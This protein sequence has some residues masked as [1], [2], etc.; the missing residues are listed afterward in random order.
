MS[1]D[2]LQEPTILY[3]DDQPSHLALF[4]RAFERD[5]LV[6]TARNG[7]EGIEIIKENELFLIIADHNMPGMTGID[8]LQRARPYAPKAANAILSAYL[9]DE[10]KEAAKRAKISEQL[11][12]PWKLDR[13]RRFIEE[14]FRRY[15]IGEPTGAVR[16][17]PVPEI[18]ERPVSAHE[19]C[20]FVGR[21]EGVAD[22]A[23]ARRI[24]LKY[25][26]PPLK[27]YV[28]MIRRP[29]HP[30]LTLAQ[31]EALKGNIEA[32]QAILVEYFRGMGHPQEQPL[33]G[34]TSKSAL[35]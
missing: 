32:V 12:K 25:V 15:E 13:M 18:R 9:N 34:E 5:Y 3:V 19:I 2:P 11:T 21:L 29:T 17:D 16:P 28:P 10:I 26:E 4:K 7:E 23:G 30:L 31:Q 27:R 20:R 14:A 33:S 35:H 8:F 24:L 1:C 22:K 6:L